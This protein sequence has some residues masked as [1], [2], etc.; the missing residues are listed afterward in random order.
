[1]S[2]SSDFH[3]YHLGLYETFLILHTEKIV[4]PFHG[5]AHYEHSA[6]I[7]KLIRLVNE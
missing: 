3:S 5:M 7:K 2:E 6:E 4:Q 1:M